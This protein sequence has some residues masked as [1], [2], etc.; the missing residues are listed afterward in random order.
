MD[1]RELQELV[2]DSRSIAFFGG[3]GTSTESGIPDFRSSTGLFRTAHGTSHPPEV[4]LSRDFFDRYP[5]EFYR[6][7]KEKMI[8]RAALPNDGHKALADLEAAGKLKALITQNIDGLHQLAG[9]RNVLELHG[10][11]HRNFC[12]VC[13][14]SYTLGELL[15]LEGPVPKCQSCGGTVKPDVVLYQEPLNTGVFNRAEEAVTQADMLIVAG[16]SLSVYPAAGLIR[17][18]SGRTLLL[19]N[20]SETKYDSYATHIVNDSFSAVMT[21]LTEPERG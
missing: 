4:M 12:T 21:R 6:F 15:T 5:A 16:T 17:Y 2:R 3:A 13:E 19:I 7:Y 8:H 11:V 10:S 9:S 18:F 1:H 14:Q 20:K